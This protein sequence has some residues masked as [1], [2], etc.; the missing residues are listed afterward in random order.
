MLVCNR[1]GP[2][3]KCSLKRSKVFTGRLKSVHAVNTF[4]LILPKT[5]PNT[6]DKNLL[7]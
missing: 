4:W 2:A 7:S 1:Y 6:G 5:H 3:K